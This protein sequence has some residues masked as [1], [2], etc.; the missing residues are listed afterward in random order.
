MNRLPKNLLHNLFTF[1][2]TKIHHPIR[3]VSIFRTQLLVIDRQK[4]AKRAS[5]NKL[6]TSTV[7]V[8]VCACVMCVS[9]S[10]Y[11]S[12]RLKWKAKESPHSRSPPRSHRHPHPP[13]SGLLPL[14]P[15]FARVS[16]ILGYRLAQHFETS[17]SHR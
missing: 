1:V 13:D 11:N 15:L 14:F 6:R 10:L 2:L 17:R 16:L 7:R 8:Y 12:V 9:I 3:A 4:H 5:V